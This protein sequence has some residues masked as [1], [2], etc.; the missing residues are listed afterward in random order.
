MA[1]ITATFG[2]VEYREGGVIAIPLNFA[3]DAIVPSKSICRIT[4]VSGSDLIGV[5]YRITGKKRAFEVVL[6]VPPDRKGSFS[7][8]I[9][10][11]VLN[12]STRKWDTVTVA[13]KTITY[14]TRI[15]RIVNYDIPPDY[16][17]G[18]K[19]DV[20]MDVGI[21]ATGLHANNVQDVFILEGAANMMGT[22]TPYKWTG[23]KPPNLQTVL[24]DDLTSTDWQQLKSPPAGTPTPGSNNFDA[25]GQWHGESGR[26]FLVRWTV[27]KG[28]TGVFNMTLRENSIR[29]PV[30]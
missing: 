24:P 8:A 29:G 15:P 4:R 27:S 11:T 16:T 22:P 3:A 19:F 21:V 28:T 2:T 20:K 14:D 26:Y 12:A 30:Q 13:A 7:I 5:N 18:E 9:N 23:T 1:S 25:D 17:V 6:E 10:A